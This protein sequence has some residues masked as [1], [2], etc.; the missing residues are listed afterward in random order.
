MREK[1]HD[2]FFLSLCRLEEVMM[3]SKDTRDNQKADHPKSTLTKTS[4]QPKTK[5]FRDFVFIP[6]RD[7]ARDSLENRSNFWIFPIY[8]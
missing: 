7:C 4:W 2:S 8:H 6:P 3:N 5:K 1:D